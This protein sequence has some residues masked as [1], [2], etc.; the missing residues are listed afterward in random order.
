M[1]VGSRLL[2]VAIGATV[3]S[4]L[5]ACGPQQLELPAPRPLITQTGERLR[6]EPERIAEIDQWVRAEIDSITLDP[7]FL[8]RTTVEVEAKYP[9][10]ALGIL[11]D[12]AN[13]RVEATSPEALSVFQIY[14]HL[15]LMK[16]LGRDSVWIPEAGGQDG[17]ELEKAI[18]TRTSDAWLYARSIFDAIPYSILDELMFSKEQGYLDAFILVARP[19]EFPDELE[20]WRAANPGQEEEYAQWF[21]RVFERPPPGRRGG[22]GVGDGR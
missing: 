13:M 21:E 14:A 5:W 20:A 1:N 12:T 22:D 2:N 6:A 18:L 19:D 17:Y 4:T 10:E 15:H 3:A 7:S 16:T 9:W 8:I 11:A